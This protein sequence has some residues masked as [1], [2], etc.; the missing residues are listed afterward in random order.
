MSWK[1]FEREAERYESWYATTRGLRASRAETRLLAWLLA[2]FPGDHTILEVGCGSGHFLPWLAAR[3]HRPIGLD[4][5][6]RMLASSRQRLPTLP[7]LLADAH[8]LPLRARAVDLVLFVTTLEFLEDPSRALAEAARVARLGILAIVLNRRSLAALSRR[9]GRASRGTLLRHA[10]DFTP[11]E[12]RASLAQ[13]AGARL[14]GLRTRCA[15]LPALP[16]RVL[17][18]IPVGDVVGV[19]AL[20]EGSSVPRS[21]DWAAGRARSGALP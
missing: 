2:A 21:R 12:V 8:A 3:G 10:R 9:F 18:R 1:L 20:L 4:R 7:A 14:R 17:T 13:A 11:R 19:A 6:P 15:L 16:A 5:A